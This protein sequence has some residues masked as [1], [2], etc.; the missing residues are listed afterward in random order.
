M[1]HKH[2]RERD[3]E[4]VRSHYD[5]GNDFYSLWLDRS[6]VYSCAYFPTGSEDI[7]AAQRAKPSGCY[8]GR[9]PRAAVPYATGTGARSVQLRR[10]R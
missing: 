4:A 6:L 1:G 9:P 7:D 5:V 10:V 2:S 8:S 3:R